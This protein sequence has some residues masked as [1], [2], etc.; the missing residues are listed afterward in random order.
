M[1][2]D[3]VTPDAAADLT[4]VGA[5]LLNL[6]YVKSTCFGGYVMSF[7]P[8]DFC[9]MLNWSRGWAGFGGTAGEAVAEGTA[10]EDLLETG[11]AAAYAASSA[12]VIRHDE[13]RI[14]RGPGQYGV[15]C[16][17]C[18]IWYSP[19]YARYVDSIRM[20][21]AERHPPRLIQADNNVDGSVVDR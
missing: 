4:A 20:L 6:L 13:I 21:T 16:N 18:L 9:L 14:V 8:I 7:R 1:A 3:P 12:V 5:F 2:T 10:L 15:D 11:L 19:L 17:L